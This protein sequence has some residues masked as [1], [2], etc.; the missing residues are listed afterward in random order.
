MTYGGDP[1]NDNVDAV[2]SLIGDTSNNSNTEYMSDAQ[3]NWRLVARTPSSG[4][5]TDATL[6]MAA[7]DCARMIAS[8]FADKVPRSAIQISD[9]PNLVYDQFMALSKELKAIALEVASVDDA[10]IFAGGLTDT[11]KKAF[12]DD[13]DKTQ[14]VF[15]RGLHSKTDADSLKGASY[16]DEELEL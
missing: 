1:A 10:E 16:V 12:E 9:T 11:T 13:T 7:S 6:Y 5:V 15:R 4:T 2:R 14:G 3:I 8:T